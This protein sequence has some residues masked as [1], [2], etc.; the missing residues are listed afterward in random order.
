MSSGGAET[1]Q[2]YLARGPYYHYS[3]NRDS[4]DKSTQVQVQLG[5][6]GAFSPANANIFVVSWFSRGVEL[7]TTNGSIQEVRS[8][9]V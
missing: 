9:S 5:F 4:E 7:T 1:F 2:D 3:F 8:L 6:E